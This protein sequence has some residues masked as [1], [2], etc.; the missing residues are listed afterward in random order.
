MDT[1]A[2]WKWTI[3]DEMSTMQNTG[4]EMT[5]DCNENVVTPS[6]LVQLVRYSGNVLFLVFR[7]FHK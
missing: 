2:F 6:A 7:V 3:C 4:K 5:Y 1:Y